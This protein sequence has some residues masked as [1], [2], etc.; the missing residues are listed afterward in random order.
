MFARFWLQKYGKW[1]ILTCLSPTDPEERYSGFH[2][3][4][5]IRRHTS[6]HECYF[7][8]NSAQGKKTCKVSTEEISMDLS[9]LVML[10]RKHVFKSH[11]LLFFTKHN[12]HKCMWYDGI[13]SII[14]F[15]LS[16][17]P[18]TGYYCFRCKEFI[19]IQQIAKLK[20]IFCS[21]VPCLK[22]LY[23]YDKA[24]WPCDWGFYMTL[25]HTC[26]LNETNREN[27]GEH[28][29]DA[30]LISIWMSYF[31][32]P[33]PPPPVDFS[34]KIV[35]ANRGPCTVSSASGTDHWT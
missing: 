24:L 32:L 18:F 21:G 29:N 11:F 6:I 25:Q 23:C 5:C 10:G 8:W 27:A 26:S 12:K 1:D 13:Y 16:G 15:K 20:F 22:H 14:C 19:L 2:P 28:A 3:Q 17:E 33:P 34:T 30:S 4:I 35:V 9:Q 31:N 7:K